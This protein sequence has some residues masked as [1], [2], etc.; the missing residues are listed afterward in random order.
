LNNPVVYPTR[1]A[2]A[3]LARFYAVQEDFARTLEKRRH[4]D[5]EVCR[6][7]AR[8]EEL[9][10]EMARGPKQPT[11]NFAEIAGGRTLGG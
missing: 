9:R 11:K 1:K 3:A 4:L 7:L 5:D 6:L 8:L 2:L 10:E